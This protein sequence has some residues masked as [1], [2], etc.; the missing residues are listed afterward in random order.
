MFKYKVHTFGYKNNYTVI[1]FHKGIEKKRI[2][3]IKVNNCNDAYKKALKIL[4]I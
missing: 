2:E 1:I 3:K 4:K